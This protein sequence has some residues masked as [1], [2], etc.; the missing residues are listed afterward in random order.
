[1]LHNLAGLYVHTGRYSEAEAM[2][3]KVLEIDRHVLGEEHPDYAMDLKSLA[4]LYRKTGR[5]ADAER[6]YRQAE[7]ILE[8]LAEN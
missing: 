6:M 1:M 5:H 2:L 7:Q 8:Q 4:N 3:E